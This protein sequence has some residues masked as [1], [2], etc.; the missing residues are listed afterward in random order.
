M[1]DRWLLKYALD[2]LVR[3]KHNGDAPTCLSRR[4]YAS[5]LGEWAVRLNLDPFNLN[6]LVLIREAIGS[7]LPASVEHNSEHSKR[8]YRN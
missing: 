4:S 3:V 1:V 7:H 6:K 2:E 8:A 5:A